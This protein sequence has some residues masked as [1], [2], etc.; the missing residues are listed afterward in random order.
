MKNTSKLLI[1]FVL[2]QLLTSCFTSNKNKNDTLFIEEDFVPVEI[3]NQYE[4]SVPKYMKEAHDLNDDASL[5]YKN[6]YK[7]TYIVVIDEP[8]EEMISTFKELEEYND[9]LSVI[10]N[11]KNIQLHILNEVIDINMTSDPKSLQISG[12]DA[13]FVEFDGKIE[14]LAFDISYF[15]TF[16]EGKEN[17]YMIMAWTL[18]NRKEKYRKA[19]EMATKSFRLIDN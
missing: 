9:S 19:F 8:K 17:V 16:I 12:L 15:L 11:Y 4:L 13:E 10:K 18:K 5:Q 2:G 3:N 1:L 7:E 14:G 6:I